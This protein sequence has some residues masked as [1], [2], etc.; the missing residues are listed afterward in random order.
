M[1]VFVEILQNQNNILAAILGLFFVNTALNIVKTGAKSVLFL[2][3]RRVKK[4][5]KIK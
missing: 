1:D 2:I 5:K 4:E 3:D